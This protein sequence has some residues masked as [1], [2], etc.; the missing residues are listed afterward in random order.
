M[1]VT[2]L[3]NA[4]LLA[5]TLVFAMAFA[6]VMELPGKLRFDGPAW[7]MVQHN[8][9][10]AFGPLAAVLEPLAIVLAWALT[11]TLWRSGQPYRRALLAAFCTTLGLIEWAVVVSPMNTL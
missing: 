5:V 7:L 6:H 11:M 4:A 8:L 3:R 9:Y 2:I 10:V 1:R